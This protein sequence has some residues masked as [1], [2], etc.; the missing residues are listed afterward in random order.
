MNASLQARPGQVVLV[1]I[2]GGLAIQSTLTVE[3]VDTLCAAL[4]AEKAKALDLL[5][6]EKER[7]TAATAPAT[8]QQLI[9]GSGPADITECGGTNH[10]R[11]G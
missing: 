11:C 8:A 6:Q 2:E 9:D 1:L 5:T 7:Q 3:D 4:R 10:V